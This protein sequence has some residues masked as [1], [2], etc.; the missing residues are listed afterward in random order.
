[1]LFCWHYYYLPLLV[2]RTSRGRASLYPLLGL[3]RNV[4]TLAVIQQP[5]R[6]NKR[7]SYERL[8]DTSGHMPFYKREAFSLDRPLFLKGQHSA[9]KPIPTHTLQRTVANS[10][11]LY[12]H[13][14]HKCQSYHQHCTL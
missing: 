11:W 10:M 7:A 4:L 9:T 5:L 12:K 1:M 13:S 14:A 2:T 3:I 8:A 6:F